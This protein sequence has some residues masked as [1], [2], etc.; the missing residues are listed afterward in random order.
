M[1]RRRVGSYRGDDATLKYRD[2]EDNRGE[3]K[4]KNE[5][6]RPGLLPPTP[7]KRRGGSGGLGGC[8]TPPPPLPGNTSKG[9]VRS[10]CDK[11]RSEAKAREER[12]RL[13]S[14]AVFT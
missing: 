14:N 12:G 8:Y 3:A 9:R 1:A 10:S 13:V 5:F 6:G 4:R 7:V 2:E 11:R